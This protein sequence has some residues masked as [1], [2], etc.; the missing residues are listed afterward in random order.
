[1]YLDDEEDDGQITEVVEVSQVL[2]DPAALDDDHY[3][4]V[5]IWE[6]IWLEASR[7]MRSHHNYS[8]LESFGDLTITMSHF[9]IDKT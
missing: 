1:M 9:K 4:V 2:D 7:D 3:L 8:M 5:G 6:I